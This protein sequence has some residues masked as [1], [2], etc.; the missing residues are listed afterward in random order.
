[1]NREMYNKEMYDMLQSHKDN[2]KKHKEY[3]ENLSK[4]PF[5]GGRPERETI[6]DENDII[7]LKIAL[8]TSKNFKEF[9]SLV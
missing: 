3:L 7:N 2:L 9:L 4:I 6:I 1:M 8:E 5:L